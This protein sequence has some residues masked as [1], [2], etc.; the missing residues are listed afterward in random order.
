[1]TS[2]V[3]RQITAGHVRHFGQFLHD[4]VQSGLS[5]VHLV[6]EVVQHPAVK[7]TKQVEKLT[8][9]HGDSVLPEN[10]FLS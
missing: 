6:T 7:T 10:K 2:C 5:V 1:M 8:L 3:A 4:V 9:K